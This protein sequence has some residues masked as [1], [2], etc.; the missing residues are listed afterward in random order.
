MISRTTHSIEELAAH[1]EAAEA[2][3]AGRTVTLRAWNTGLAQGAEV[4]VP[5]DRSKGAMVTS[6]APLA[7]GHFAELA[8]GARALVETEGGISC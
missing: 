2:K 3:G 8:R 6:E 7:P 5:F 4:E 1:L